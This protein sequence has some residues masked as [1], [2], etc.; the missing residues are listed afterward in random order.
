[1]AK[2]RSLL[3][4]VIGIFVLAITLGVVTQ[5]AQ[6]ESMV[7]GAG[8]I[9]S[10]A[11]CCRIESFWNSA[12]VAGASSEEYYKAEWMDHCT[13]SITPKIEDGKVTGT[14]AIGMYYCSK[15]ST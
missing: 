10:K 7:G 1:M 12:T 5:P 9:Y 6:K 3:I 13:K 11:F 14:T 2:D 4:A 8:G 15:A